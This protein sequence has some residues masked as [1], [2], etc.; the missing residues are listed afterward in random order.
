MLTYRRPLLYIDG[1]YLVRRDDHFIS[2]FRPCSKYYH[3]SI[4]SSC[5]SSPATFTN[6]LPVLRTASSSLETPLHQHVPYE[7]L[8]IAYNFP[9]EKEENST[10][11]VPPGDGTFEL[12]LTAAALTKL[13][14][15]SQSEKTKG[16]ILLIAVEFGGC[17]G[18]QYKFSLVPRPPPESKDTNNTSYEVLPNGDLFFELPKVQ[19]GILMDETTFKMIH[20]SHLNYTNELIGSQFK[21]VDNPNADPGCG[22]GVSFG[23]KSST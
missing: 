1:L 12:T 9:S 8:K 10:V 6:P 3:R 14:Q 19:S 18:F 7:P 13:A 2:S 15:L 16:K 11:K 17:H 21:I 20:G 22:C 4:S 5:G 23:L